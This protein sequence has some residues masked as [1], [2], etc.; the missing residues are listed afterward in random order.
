MNGP[1]NVT[2]S[3]VAIP[4]HL[5]DWV[6]EIDRASPFDERYGLSNGAKQYFS[7]N[8]DAAGLN[9]WTSIDLYTTRGRVSPH[10][11]DAGHTYGLV[12]IADGGHDLL[13]SFRGGNELSPQ[14]D[15]APGCVY[16]IDSNEDHAT[17]CRGDAKQD[18]LA[19]LTLD[20]RGQE[21]SLAYEDFAELALASMEA[22][23]S[24][25]RNCGTVL[26][27]TTNP[28]DEKS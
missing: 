18:L 1:P 28:R 19:I 8:P 11:D 7:V 6:R 5:A 16:H 27:S 24:K 13:A 3:L 22:A 15:L 21:P 23:F 4:P 9:D 17:S 26:P 12:L 20:F 14:G 2:R 25:I 10:Q